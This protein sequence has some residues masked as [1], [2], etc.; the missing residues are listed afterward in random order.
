MSSVSP[1]KAELLQIAVMGGGGRDG[2]RDGG[3][4]EGADSIN[5][6]QMI[7]LN[8]ISACR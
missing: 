1:E 2:G 4:G 3:S 8:W 6:V 5:F 7:Q